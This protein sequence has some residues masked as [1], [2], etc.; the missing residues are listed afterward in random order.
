MSSDGNGLWR[1]QKLSASCRVNTLV[2]AIW[3]LRQSDA[4]TAPE[5]VLN[6]SERAVKKLEQTLTQVRDL[7]GYADTPAPKENETSPTMPGSR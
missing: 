2:N 7:E 1:S 3:I 5:R 6:V 4:P